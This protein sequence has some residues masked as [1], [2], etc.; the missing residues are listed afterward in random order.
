MKSVLVKTSHPYEVLVGDGLLAQS[1]QLIAKKIKPCAA[2]IIAD[3]SVDI[4]FGDAVQASLQ[5]AGFRVCRIVFSHGE[6]SK[7]LMTLSTVLEQLAG[8]Q[9]TRTDLIVALGGGV[10]GDLAG[11]A[12]AVYLRG[13]RFVQIPTTFLAAIDSSVGGKTA[14]DLASGKNL[15]GV[16]WQPEL[17]LCDCETLKTLPEQ[18]FLDGMGEAVKYGMA[19]DNTLLPL[20]YD[21]VRSRIPEIIARCVAIKADVV[22]QDELDTGERRKLNFG[23]TVGHAIERCSSFSISHG[24]AVAIG[25]VII[26][27]ACVK[28][29]IAPLETLETLLYT[30]NTCGLPVSCDYSA[31]AL[32][33]A[34]LGDKK[35]RGDQ[36]ALIL[37]IK[38]GNCI[39]QDIAVNTLSAW[40]KLGL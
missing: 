38:V 24:Q 14:V 28:K 40:I 7:N 2:A 36:L 35:R 10:S 29:G 23:H 25:M 30:L 27:R 22:A 4:L 26:T 15:A 11:F 39:V 13:I 16:F 34:A 31:T 21:K 18:Y 37:P 12:A 33:E 17:V 8:Y 6:A 9:I 20:L 3:D 5:Q 32:A 1:G 19:F